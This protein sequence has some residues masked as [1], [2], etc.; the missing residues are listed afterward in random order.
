MSI[1][2][3]DEIVNGSTVHIYPDVTSMSDYIAIY[4]FIHQCFLC[5][6]FEITT[7]INEHIETDY[8]VCKDQPV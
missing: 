3:T 6:D 5:S 4:C 2:L 1:S 7:L 8:D